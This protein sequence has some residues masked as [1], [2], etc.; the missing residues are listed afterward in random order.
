MS[1]EI[2]GKLRKLKFHK[3]G[4]L[5]KSLFTLQTGSAHNIFRVVAEFGSPS[6]RDRSPH[7]LHQR[8]PLPRHAQGPRRGCRGSVRGRPPR[9]PRVTSDLY[10]KA[11]SALEGGPAS[12]HPTART[13]ICISQDLTWDLDPVC[14]PTA[15]A[16]QYP[17][18][19]QRL[20]LTA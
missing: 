4:A 12:R 2:S 13:A 6:P 19:W 15:G 8:T 17:G 3:R 20:A 14:Q 10:L 11:L 1:H 18:F 7:L 9:L 16:V 5:V